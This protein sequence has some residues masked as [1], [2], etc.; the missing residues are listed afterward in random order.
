M[1]QSLLSFLK[2]NVAENEI[3]VS[4]AHRRKVDALNLVPGPSFRNR[5]PGE[6]TNQYRRKT[7]VRTRVDYLGLVSDSDSNLR[8]PR[9]SQSGLQIA[10]ACER[11]R[12]IPVG[13]CM[14]LTDYPGRRIVRMDAFL[15]LLRWL[16][17][18]F[19]ITWIGLLYYFNF[20]Q[21]PFFAEAE[22]PV[23]SGAQQKLL[24]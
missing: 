19:G 10:S 6:C 18:L 11:E 5:S 4:C 24:P 17:F 20:V 16:H 9:R 14:G 1:L 13:V 2:H 8:G 12:P 22:P 7:S 21:T 3:A 15:M 23:R